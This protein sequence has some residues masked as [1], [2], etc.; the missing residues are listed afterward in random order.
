M[1]ASKSIKI[2]IISHSN[3]SINECYFR[4]VLSCSLNK[5]LKLYSSFLFISTGIQILQIINPLAPEE[6]WLTQ[7]FSTSITRRITRT[8]RR[9]D[10]IYCFGCKI[11]VSYLGKLSASCRNVRLDLVI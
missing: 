10:Q 2:A 1:F 7:D 5:T 4:N 9:L 8:L 3:I 6:I 11:I